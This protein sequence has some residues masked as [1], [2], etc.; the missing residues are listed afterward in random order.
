MI[1]GSLLSSTLRRVVV[2]F[3]AIGIA[4]GVGERVRAVA[5]TESGL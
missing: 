1:T 4:D 5:A 3:I 2:L